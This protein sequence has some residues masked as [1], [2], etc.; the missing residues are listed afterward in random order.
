MSIGIY[1]IENRINGKIY[2]GQSIHIEKRWSE[3]CQKSSNSLIGKAIKEY[4]KENF[5]FQILEEVEDITLLNE[6]ETKYIKQYNCLTPYGYNIIFDDNQEHHQFNKYDQDTFF[7]IINLIKNT[8][9]S[10][11]EISQLYDLDLS[12][13]YYLNRGD[14]HTLPDEKYPLREVKDFSKKEHYCIDC[15]KPI[16][17]GAT[18][19]IKCDHKNQ[20]VVERPSREV[21]KLMI[22]NEPF[23]K[24]GKN[25]NVTD[26]T[27][28]KWCKKENLPYK[29]SEIK[30]ISEED[31][32]KI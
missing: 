8:S 13:I 9:I 2:V 4:G 10:F 32:K 30:K 25:F 19:C 26:T 16:S 6:L 7:E 15:G 21:L 31:W 27:I 12:M 24:I 11:K 1:K 17:K 22:R 3:H 20:Q 28:R 14:Y 23:T 29:A 18:R 5:S